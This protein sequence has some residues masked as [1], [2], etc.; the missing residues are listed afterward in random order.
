MNS[1]PRLFSWLVSLGLAICQAKV[2]WASSY[3]VTPVQVFLSRANS[4]ALLTLKN[5]S[6]ETLRFQ[7]TVSAWDQNPQDEMRLQPTDDIVLFPAI[8][9]VGPGEERKLRVAVATRFDSIEKTYRILFEELPA[10]EKSQDSQPSQIRI[11]TRTSIPVFLE[12]LRVVADTHVEALALQEGILSFNVKNAGNVHAVVREVRVKG[13][14]T[15]GETVFARTVPGWYVL[16]GDSRAFRVEIPK[17]DCG[18]VNRVAIE[19]Q[20]D[21]KTLL[22]FFDPTPVPCP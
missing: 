11:L 10:L 19:A 12:P 4:R 9:A 14:G 20:T 21:R 22:E 13:L 3:K 1:L 7:V 2:S 18:R 8:L 16:G 15:A 5:E 6:V 17:E